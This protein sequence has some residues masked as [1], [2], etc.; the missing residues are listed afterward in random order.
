MARPIEDIKNINDFKN[1]WKIVVRIKDLWFV[2]TMANKEHLEIFVIDLKKDMIQVT[3]PP[4]LVPKHKNTF[5]IGKTYIIQNVKVAK[6]DFTFKA[7]TYN[8]KLI[9]MEQLL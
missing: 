6:N 8:F 4:H 5:K 3:V 9:L 2:T 1:L 7:T